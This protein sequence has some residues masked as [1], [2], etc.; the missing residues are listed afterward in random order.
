MASQQS[1]A[2]GADMRSGE[3]AR[4]GMLMRVGAAVVLVAVSVFVTRYAWR[5]LFLIAYNEPESN[6]VL[7]VPLVVLWLAWDRRRRLASCDIRHTWAGSA[8]LLTGWA[9]WSVGYRFEFQV[10]W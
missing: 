9:L 3:S 10:F 6:Y 1:H 4:G 7:L 5:D 8:F 2:T